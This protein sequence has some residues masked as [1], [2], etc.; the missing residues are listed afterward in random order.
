MMI[1]IARSMPK[2]LTR[3]PTKELI[4]IVVFESNPPTMT[5]RTSVTGSDV[6]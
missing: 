6:I 5:I 1:N 3:S 4:S 2:V